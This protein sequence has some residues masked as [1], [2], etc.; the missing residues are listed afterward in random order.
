MKWTLEKWLTFAVFCSLI[1]FGHFCCSHFFLTFLLM[2]GKFSRYAWANGPPDTFARLCFPRHCPTF[3]T[4]CS[5]EFCCGWGGIYSNRF[6]LGKRTRTFCSN[7]LCS[8][9]FLKTFSGTHLENCSCFKRLA[10]GNSEGLP[11]PGFPGFSSLSSFVPTRTNHTYRSTKKTDQRAAFVL[12]IVID[13]TWLYYISK[14]A[15]F[16]AKRSRRP[17]KAVVQVQAQ[18]PLQEGWPNL[19]GVW[20]HWHQ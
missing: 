19:E 11:V 2:W 6:L 7:S 1:I 3:W 14:V 13:L 9:I 10:S 8:G 18:A 15:P 12:K 4:A 17:K 20:G 16:C 5:Q